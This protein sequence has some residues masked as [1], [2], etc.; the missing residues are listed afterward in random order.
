M[1]TNKELSQEQ[2]QHL[3]RWLDGRV[4]RASGAA[5]HDP[6]DVITDIEVI[7]AKVTRGRGIIVTKDMWNKIRNE[8]HTGRRALIA[9]RWVDERDKPIFDL[10]VQD[11]DD[12]YSDTRV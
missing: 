11:F 7:E 10:I 12:Y 4:T 1:K 8:T 6:G 2:E 3:A 5:K 9:L